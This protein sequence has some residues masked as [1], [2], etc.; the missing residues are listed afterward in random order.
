MQQQHPQWETG[1]DELM[2]VL[3]WA[4]TSPSMHLEWMYLERKGDQGAFP[5]TRRVGREEM[6]NSVREEGEVISGMLDCIHQSR[7]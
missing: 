5:E 4:V 3:G 1:R 6:M 2:V 7:L